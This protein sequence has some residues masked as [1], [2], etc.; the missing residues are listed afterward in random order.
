MKRLATWAAKGGRLDGAELSAVLSVRMARARS[1]ADLSGLVDRVESLGIDRR[2]FE[3]IAA[4][5]NDPESIRSEVYLLEPYARWAKRCRPALAAPL[6]PT[7]AIFRRY[8]RSVRRSNL[9]ASTLGKRAQGVRT[10]ARWCVA[11]GLLEATELE[12]ILAHPVRGNRNPSPGRIQ[13]LAAARTANAGRVEGRLAPSGNDRAI[14][15]L[16]ERFRARSE[17]E[18]RPISNAH[19]W[20]SSCHSAKARRWERTWVA[21]PGWSARASF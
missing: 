5:G 8:L 10:Y 3:D 6:T 9:A 20:T 13:R 17:G 1:R 14:W 18:R 19:P 11:T 4:R 16:P 2:Y 12:A 21:V 7:N 15:T